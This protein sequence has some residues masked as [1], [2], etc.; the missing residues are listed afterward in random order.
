MNCELLQFCKLFE[1]RG[2]ILPFMDQSLGH[3]VSKILP[4]TTPVFSLTTLHGKRYSR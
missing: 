2:P 3:I 1:T 4:F